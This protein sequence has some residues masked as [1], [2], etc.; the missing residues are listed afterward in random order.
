[1]EEGG[2]DVAWFVV[3]VGQG[4]L[5]DEGYAQATQAAMDK[6]NAI[7]WLAE[8]KAPDRIEIAYTSDDVRRIAA[9]GRRWP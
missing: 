6:F 2:L 7:H 3:F 9:S 4:D 5:T 8:D 1:M